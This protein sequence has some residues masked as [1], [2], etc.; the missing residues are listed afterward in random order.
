MENQ[1]NNLFIKNMN[2]FDN[3]LLNIKNNFIETIID[4]KEYMVNNLHSQN[5]ILDNYELLFEIN[6]TKSIKEFNI[7]IDGLKNN[8][9]CEYEKYNSY[10]QVKNNEIDNLNIELKKNKINISN[11]LNEMKQLNH[12]INNNKKIIEEQEKKLNYLTEQFQQER[13]EQEYKKTLEYKKCEYYIKKRKTHLREFLVEPLMSLFE[14][15]ELYDDKFISEFNKL[16]S[17]KREIIKNEIKQIEWNSY[18]PD[19]EKECDICFTNKKCKTCI[20][21]CNHS[22]CLTCYLANPKSICPFCR[23]DTNI[24]SEKNILNNTNIQNIDNILPYNTPI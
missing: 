12:I 9:L 5:K 11:L 6:K 2:K 20:Y 22:I 15:R 7:F 18:F 23:S 3:V 8:I 4:N 10:I 17:E 16:F 14:I 21:E 13:L 19:I 24:T 1:N